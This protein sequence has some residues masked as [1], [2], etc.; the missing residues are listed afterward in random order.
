MGLVEPPKAQVWVSWAA[1][2]EW[3][4]VFINPKYIRELTSD[5]DEAIN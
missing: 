1:G 2:K 3:R 4:W 5:S